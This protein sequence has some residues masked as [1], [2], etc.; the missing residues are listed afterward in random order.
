M[1]FEQRPVGGEGESTQLHREKAFQN[2]GPAIAKSVRQN[3]AWHV[4]EAP[5]R[6]LGYEE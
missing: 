6:L 3:S 1:T 5:W 4:E 2:E